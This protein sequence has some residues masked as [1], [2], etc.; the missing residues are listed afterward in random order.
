MA[1]MISRL[2]AC[3]VLTTCVVVVPFGQPASA[4]FVGS[5]GFS[6]LQIQGSYTGRP[7]DCQLFCPKAYALDGTIDTTVG[8][9]LFWCLGSIR[10]VTQDPL[11]PGKTVT[12][13]AIGFGYPQVCRE[14]DGTIASI[15]L[16]GVA[17]RSDAPAFQRA[18]TSVGVWID[19]ANAG[20]LHVGSDTNSGSW[21]IPA[22]ID[23]ARL[24]MRP[25]PFPFDVP[26][27]CL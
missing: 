1:R 24:N 25:G 3:L 18:N 5:R 19:G 22:T 20:K 6:L 7:S 23:L 17:S 21:E 26:L 10:A 11:E 14:Q 16:L 27:Y 2:A 4:Q 8:C 13:G 12:L 15:Q 9:F